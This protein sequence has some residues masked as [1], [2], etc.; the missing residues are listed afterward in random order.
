MS[1]ILINENTLDKLLSKHGVT[2]REV[3]QCFDNLCGTYLLEN[4]EEHRSEPPTLW[5]IAPTN[6][7][8]LLKIVFI[9][10][11]G[12]IRIKSAFPPNSD[13]ICI[14]EKIGK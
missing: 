14:Y 13:E 6:H 10:I 11:D 8:R 4:R 3:E 1:V 7:D 12:N 2:R 5:F 9:F